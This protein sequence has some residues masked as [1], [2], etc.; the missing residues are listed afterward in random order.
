MKKRSCF[1][2]GLGLVAGAVL[3]MSQG[4]YAAEVGTLDELKAC[5]H[6]GSDET[7]CVLTDDIEFDDTIQVSKN[8]ELDLNGHTVVPTGNGEFLVFQGNM[9]ITGE[10]TVGSADSN[11]PFYVWGSTNETA[12]NF[13]TLTIGEDV[14]VK[15]NDTNGWGIVVP[16]Y[17]KHAYGV[18]VNLNGAIEASS[19]ITINGYVQDVVDNAPILNIGDTA[20]ITT[21]GHIVYGAGYGHWTF[22]RAEVTGGSGI[23]IKAGT[24]EFNGTT[25]AATGAYAEP[26]AWGNGMNESGATFQIEDHDGYA[27]NVRLT[28]NDGV[29]TSTNGHVFYE[30]KATE[31]TENAIQDLT[32]N[33]GKF[34]AGDGKTVFQVSDNFAL[35]GFIVEGEFSSEPEHSYVADGKELYD[36]SQDGPWVVDEE[37]GVDFPKTIYLTVGETYTLEPTDTAKKYLSTSNVAVADFD[38]ET[39]TFTATTV[40]TGTFNYQLHNYIRDEVDDN[41]EITVVDS[42]ELEVVADEDAGV[43]AEIVAEITEKLKDIIEGNTFVAEDGTKSWVSEDGMLWADPEAVKEAIANGETLTIV[44][45]N[46]RIPFENL[47][48]ENQATLAQMIDENDTVAG[49]WDIEFAILNESGAE[50]GGVVALESPI[51]LS[52]EVPENLRKAAEGYTRKFYVVRYHLDRT[53]GEEIDRFEAKFDGGKA[54][55]END[56]FSVFILTYQDEKNVEAPDTGAFT[57]ATDYAQKH[58]R[59]SVMILAMGMM[60]VGYGLIALGKEEL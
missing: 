5:L 14:T 38:G 44:M 52:F 8:V 45:V 49:I 40:G 26:V 42:N 17:N 15:A 12:T 47:D 21:T 13:S 4:A 59:V 43:D 30:Y 51:T 39:W 25:V 27:D 6:W 46:G 28:I 41:I 60:M 31:L 58:G 24:F 33:G 23:G 56:K 53:T 18:V 1:F 2:L 57:A 16:N 22:G 3:G 32:V 36:L 9:N 20:R 7:V 10:G 55:M 37:T 11:V 35:T 50:V 54:T 34:T 29:Y 19:A 48:E